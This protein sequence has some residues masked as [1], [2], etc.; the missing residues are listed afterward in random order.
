MLKILLFFKILII[1]KK[2]KKFNYQKTISLFLEN[3][4]QLMYKTKTINLLILKIHYKIKVICI[5]EFILKI[6]IITNFKKNFLKHTKILS[7]IGIK[8]F[9]VQEHLQ[10]TH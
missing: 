2:N 5:I 9:K 8:I 3:I 10:I 6:S 4:N 7:K 1:Y